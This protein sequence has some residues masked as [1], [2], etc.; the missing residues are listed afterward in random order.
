MLP[1]DTRVR[2]RD[3]LLRRAIPGL[4]G[5]R[6]IAALSV[7]FFH[8][9]SEHFPGRHAVQVFFVLSGLLITWLLLN[10]EQRTGRVELKVFYYRRALRLLPAL[11]ALLAWELLVGIPQASRRSILAAFLYVANY[12]F[13]VH[14]DV[15]GLAHTWSLAVEEHFYLIWP[16]VFVFA[17]NRARM[18]RPLLIVAGLGAIYR[19]TVATLWSADYAGVATESNLTGLLLGCALALLIWHAPERLPRLVLHPLMAPLSIAVIIALAQTTARMQFAWAL[20]A[21]APFA[22]ILILQ[23][24]TYEWRILENSIARY[25][26]RISYGIYLWHLV[27]VGWVDLRLPPLSPSVRSIAIVA[28]AIFIASVSHFA[29]ERPI[30]LAGWALLNRRRAAAPSYVAAA[31]S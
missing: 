13:A 14:G 11:L 30:Q 6:G 25:L 17:A 9:V 29:I 8:A 27:A 16:A 3:N 19:F 23:A 18:I 12:F 1:E 2:L 22:A 21:S 4:D 20:T 5:I 24:V 7:V 10:T 26:G 15:G 28:L 31:N